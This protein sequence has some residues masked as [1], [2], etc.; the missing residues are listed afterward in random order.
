[1]FGVARWL[2]RSGEAAEFAWA[3]ARDAERLDPLLRLTLTAA[4][5][6][7]FDSGSVGSAE[8]LAEASRRYRGGALR[9]LLAANGGP[10]GGVRRA[11]GAR[12]ARVTPPGATRTTPPS[13]RCAGRSRSRSDR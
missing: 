10:A 5:T 6:D 2:A 12:G 11:R 9:W 7:R 8:W 1:M 4:E 3:R 13:P